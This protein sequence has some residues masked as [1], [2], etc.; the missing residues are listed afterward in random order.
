MPG[1]LLAKALGQR[2]GPSLLLRSKSPSLL[3]QAVKEQNREWEP[4]MDANARELEPDAKR[5]RGLKGHWICAHPYGL[6]PRP[7]EGNAPRFDPI[8]VNLRSSAVKVWVLGSCPLPSI[9]GK[10]GGSVLAVRGREAG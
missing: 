6:V 2:L 5:R 7:R 1:K 3:C 8:R 10:K 9:R 4:R